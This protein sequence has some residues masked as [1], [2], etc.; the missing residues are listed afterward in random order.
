MGLITLLI[1]VII[2]LA[3]IGLGWKSFSTGVLSGFERVLN[4]GDTLI[5]NITQQARELVNYPNLMLTR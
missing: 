2:I 1:V 5:K 3:I 4:I